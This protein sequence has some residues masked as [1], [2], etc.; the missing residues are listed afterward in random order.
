MNSATT[1]GALL[2]L[3][4]CLS[5]S[6][7]EPVYEGPWQ[8]VVVADKRPGLPPTTT[9]NCSCNAT[10]C[11]ETSVQPG[12]GCAAQ[13]HYLPSQEYL[14]NQDVA[15]ILFGTKPSSGPA[16]L[17]CAMKLCQDSASPN[18]IPIYGPRS[19]GVLA[20]SRGSDPSTTV[21]QSETQSDSQTQS[22]TDGKQE[23]ESSTESETKGGEISGGFSLGTPGGT[24][25]LQVGG[26]RR[27]STQSGESNSDT[28]Q[29]SETTTT[30]GQSQATFA[31]STSARLVWRSHGDQLIA[32]AQAIE[33]C[34][35]QNLQSAG[36]TRWSLQ[37]MALHVL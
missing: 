35:S 11:Y 28:T 27:G 21:Q 4:T 37:E 33:A 2:T 29:T 20:I 12:P 13:R 9:F 36:W 5:V 6:A 30:G 8:T 31:R 15:Y 22:T 18:C 32:E 17:R 26:A 7:Q 34:M 3:L 14:P 1:I 16:A 19:R 25:G 23:S 10:V 24:V